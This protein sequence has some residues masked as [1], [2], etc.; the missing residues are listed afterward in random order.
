[1]NLI[2]ISDLHCGA[3]FDEKVFNTAA[4]EINA[5]DPDVIVVTGDLTEEGYLSEYRLLMEQIAKLD[6]EK[7][8]IGNGN[9]D[10]SILA[11][12]FSTN[13]FQ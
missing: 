2:H 9:H 13:F 5:L 8:V 7:V 3:R 4:E 10:I 6:C 1:M 11:T 12:C